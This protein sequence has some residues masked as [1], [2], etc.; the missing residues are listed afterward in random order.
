VGYHY[1]DEPP[2][3]LLQGIVIFNGV[4]DHDGGAYSEKIAWRVSRRIVL[5]STPHQSAGR[6]ENHQDHHAA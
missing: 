1:F 4:L 3:S 6:T 5:I 2:F